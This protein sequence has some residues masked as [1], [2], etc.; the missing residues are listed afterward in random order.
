MRKIKIQFQCL[1][2]VFIGSGCQLDYMNVTPYPCSR[3]VSDRKLYEIY[4]ENAPTAILQKF[5]ELI[6]EQKGF[7]I[8]KKYADLTETHCLEKKTLGQTVDP[9]IFDKIETNI[10]QGQIKN[11]ILIELFVQNARGVYVPGSSLKGAL[12]T[13]Y[14]K[15]NL[16][17][18][19]EKNGTPKNIEEDP[20]NHFLVRDSDNNNLKTHVGNIEVKNFPKNNQHTSMPK[21]TGHYRSNNHG[22]FYKN[23][24]PQKS[25]QNIPA[26]FQYLAPGSTFECHIKDTLSSSLYSPKPYDFR[27]THEFYHKAFEKLDTQVYKRDSEFGEFRSHIKNI[28]PSKKEFLFSLGGHGGVW[29]KKC[30][31]DDSFFRPQGKKTVETKSSFRKSVYF[32]MPIGWCQGTWEEV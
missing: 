7:L 9:E 6:K 11:Q 32:Q 27:Q 31:G 30:L 28:D 14:I 3:E 10:K 1:T 13:P 5:S 16:K 22:R 29:T 20:F 24:H 2:P 8:P 26:Y 15:N 17:F 21:G 18:Y 25:S 19:N 23:K 12:K 4:P